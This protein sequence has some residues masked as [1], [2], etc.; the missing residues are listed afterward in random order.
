MTFLLTI[1]PWK[2]PTEIYK[3]T[4]TAVLP[5]G[6]KALGITPTGA[7]YWA[8]LGRIEAVDENG[9][10]S[11]FFIKVT[12]TST[13]IHDSEMYLSNMYVTLVR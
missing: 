6:T 10:E 1:Q 3:L 13:D 11:L 8:R 4:R 5:P 7:S 9:E 2:V 12:E